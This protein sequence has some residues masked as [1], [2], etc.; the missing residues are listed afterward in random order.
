MVFAPVGEAGR[1]LVQAAGKA[2]GVGRVGPDC[3]CHLPQILRVDVHH[4]A[5][6]L[7]VAHAN[8]GNVAFAQRSFKHKLP[9][10]IQTKRRLGRIHRERGRKGAMPVVFET[11][12][13]L[14]IVLVEREVEDFIGKQVRVGAAIRK[15]R[16]DAGA[17]G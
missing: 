16:G 1:G 13:K 2:V 4:F 10:F 3:G 6:H 11:D 5:R 8:G 17:V 14:V 9:G 15:L 7:P 12:V